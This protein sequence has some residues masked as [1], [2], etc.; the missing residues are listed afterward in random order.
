[1][2]PL[3]TPM[4]TPGT[5]RMSRPNK[6]QAKENKPIFTPDWACSISTQEEFDWFTVIDA[7]GDAN[8]EQG[9]WFW[10][11]DVPCAVYSYS[12]YAYGDEVDDWLVTPGFNLKA[13]KTYNLTFYTTNLSTFYD[14]KMEV[15]IGTQPTGEGLNNELFTEFSVM[16][17]EWIENTTKFTVDHDDVY[18]IGF[19]LLEAGY[20]SRVFIDEISLTGETLG[21][22]PGSVSDL[23]V[24][25]D[26]TG[27]PVGTLKFTLPDKCADGSPLT[28]LSGVKIRNG[29]FEIADLKDVQP[30]ETVSYDADMQYADTY[31]FNVVAYNNVDEGI[32]NSATLFVGLDTPYTPQN[33]VLHDCVDKMTVTADP[34]TATH[35]GVF[36][37]EDVTFSVYEI[38]RDEYG[39]PIVGDLVASTTGS[40]EVDINIPTVVGEQ[41]IVSYVTNASNS[42]GSSPNYYQ[43]N[44]VV[45]GAPYTIPFKETFDNGQTPYFWL[46]Q[47][48]ANGFGTTGIYTSTIESFGSRPGCMILSAINADD[49]AGFYSGKI[50][51][52]GNEDSKLSF[53]IMNTSPVE[54]TLNVY[55]L[56]ADGDDCIID[57]RKVSELSTGW[58]VMNYDLGQFAS[59]RYINVG[60]QY[61]SEE[62][63]SSNQIY[64]DNIFVG[65]LPATDLRTEISSVRQAE[66]GSEISLN[67][68]VDNNG[69]AAVKSFGLTL[70]ANGEEIDRRTVECE[71]GMMERIYVTIPVKIAAIETA[72]IIEYQAIVTIDND[73]E[74]DDNTA[75]CT[76][77]LKD[78]DLSAPTDLI[79]TQED[80]KVYLEWKKVS[81]LAPRTDN[82]D[83][84]EPWNYLDDWGWVEHNVGDWTMVDID[85]GSTGGFTDVL[86]YGSQA[87]KFAYTVFNPYN[88][89]GYGQS[90]FTVIS[91]EVSASFVPHSGEQYLAGIYSA[92][93]YWDGEKY[94]GDIK[95]ADN[96]VISPEQTGE[97][98]TIRFWVNNFKGLSGNGS[99]IDHVETYQVLVSYTGMEIEDFSPVGDSR[100]ASGGQWQKVEI[101]LPE[102]TKYFAIRHCSPYNAEM[103][104]P[105]IFMIDDIT[106]SVLNK[107]LATYNIYRDGSLIDSV[108]AESNVYTDQEPINE[109]HLYQVTGVYEDGTESAPVTASLASVGI[110]NANEDKATFDIFNSTGILIRRNAK[111]FND[112]PSGIY[113]TSDGRRIYL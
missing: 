12:Y 106:Y 51:L 88:Y 110:G 32:N 43:T 76:I 28:E 8:E 94:V 91:E 77:E 75:S 61:I 5:F 29:Y 102:G 93:T 9:T 74:A 3:G 11:S 81:H 48:K 14:D 40:T 100:L 62:R 37:P 25:P 64:F 78:P 34:F 31:T 17:D 72:D 84:Y 26:P 104:T 111:N 109:K 79:L 41:S 15:C 92:D 20:M 18:Y 19:H 4:A 35:D 66:R 73:A 45:L 108:G 101:D 80:G 33:V 113:I 38:A 47:V 7:N 23:T 85:L 49:I 6:S 83:S 86:Y 55:V 67:V 89:T 36:F 71:L 96:W 10:R 98:Q 13:G 54:G 87:Q 68:R 21:N 2:R 58:E 103:G 39:F 27:A 44:N 30:G 70:T 46:T 82:F 52:E 112:L 99:V 105:F 56:T 16:N 24:T 90:L 65:S 53:A 97:A 69:S 42:A 60:L 57:S 22:A 107:P 63:N 1:M 95:D 50:A 59:Q